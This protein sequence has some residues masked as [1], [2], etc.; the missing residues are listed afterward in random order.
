MIRRPPRSTLFP[1][2]TLF[3]SNR[4]VGCAGQVEGEGFV[5][6]D[7]RVADDAD[8]DDLAGLAGGERERAADAVV[9]ATSEGHPFELQL[10][11]NAVFPLL[12]QKT[13]GERRA[14]RAG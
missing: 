5:A 7:C 8:R 10:P 12:L 9:I 13:N 2:T 4:G 11:C 14:G 3:R 1:Y 6:L